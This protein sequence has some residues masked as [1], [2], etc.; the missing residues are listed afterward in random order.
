MLGRTAR[1]IGE[2]MVTE[3]L[4]CVFVGAEPAA[5]VGRGGDAVAERGAE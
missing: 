5:L 1:H 2:L 4:I 3:D